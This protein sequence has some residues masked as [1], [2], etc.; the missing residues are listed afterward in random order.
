[1]KTLL[2]QAKEVRHQSNQKRLYNEEEMDLY[3]GW[4]QGEV[5]T[6]QIIRTIFPDRNIRKGGG[7]VLYAIAGFMREGVRRG[8]IVITRIKK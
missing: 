2:E 6:T 8:D 5:S 7:S 4:V 3:L 1:M